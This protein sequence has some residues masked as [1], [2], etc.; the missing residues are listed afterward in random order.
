VLALGQTV[1]S[2]I[3]DDGP[4]PRILS[5]LPHQGLHGESI[6][7]FHDHVVL[8]RH[9]YLTTENMLNLGKTTDAALA[10]YSR[11]SGSARL[12]YVEYPDQE[13]AKAAHEAF[14]RHYLPDA[15]PSGMALLEN[16]QWCG[17]RLKGKGLAIVLEADR[18]ELAETLLKEVME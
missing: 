10:S 3:K 1:A 9:Y 15:G 12:L 11:E 7:F 6:K 16:K 13:S 8:N 14:L 17:V 5:S 18:R 2:L 4:K